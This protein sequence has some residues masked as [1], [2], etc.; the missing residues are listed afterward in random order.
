MM[1]LK[2]N[3]WAVLEKCFDAEVMAAMNDGIPVAQFGK[4]SG[5]PARL[6]AQGLIEQKTF[7]LAGRFPVKI[8]GWILTPLGHVTWCEHCQEMSA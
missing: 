8:T 3:E 7:T 2:P 1:K 4:R 6:A 5:I